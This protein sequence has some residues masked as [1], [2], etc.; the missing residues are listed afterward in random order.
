MLTVHPIYDQ[1]HL[2]IIH[3]Y[4]EGREVSTI[5]TQAHQVERKLLESNICLDSM[6]D[7]TPTLQAP[8]LNNQTPEALTA[9]CHFQ[10]RGYIPEMRRKIEHWDT[11]T[12][13]T[14]Y[15]SWSLSPQELVHGALSK[16]LKH[17]TDAA[18]SVATRDSPDL[19]L[20]NVANLYVRYRGTVGREFILDLEL[21]R[22][23]GE[24]VEKRVSLLLPHAKDFSMQVNHLEPQSSLARVNFIIPMNGLH[25]KKTAKFQRNFYTV[26]VR[27]PENCKVIYVMFS[28]SNS[29]VNFMRTYLTRFKRRHSKFVYDY[30]VGSGKFNMTEAYRLGLS[31]LNNTELA[32]IASIDV[33]LADH[34]LT[35]CRSNTQP[36]SRLYYPEVFMYYSMPY[37]YRGKWHPRNYD[38]SRLH[39]R[40]AT[41]RIMCA[42]KPDYEAIGGYNSIK[43]WE[44]DPGSIQSSVPASME[45]FIAPDPGISHWY[46]PMFCDSNLPPD[47]FSRCL[48]TRSDNLA[49]RIS[50][51]GYLLSLEN[52]CSKT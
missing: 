52:K 26:C 49:D 41:H 3:A 43:Q 23:E 31:K 35:R 42:Y 8:S 16:E 51:A 9:H 44:V 11:V 7:C 10:S 19:Q 50:L 33:S 14:K 6:D 40:W 4:S 38:Y 36:G 12:G 29:D 17:V 5:Q 27:R 13:H 37:V 46:E 39:G 48:S 15:N 1:H 25:R 28:S 2:N 32:F 30:V 34:F 20:V 47:Q 24:V 45:I 18:V 22:S 21:N